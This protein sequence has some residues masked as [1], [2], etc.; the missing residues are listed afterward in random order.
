MK[1]KN[2]YDPDEYKEYMYSGFLG[3]L[4]RRNH[5]LMEIYD[6]KDNSKILEIGG[7]FVPHFPY[8]KHSIKEYHSVDLK[9]VRGLKNYIN[10]N[11]KKIKFKYY[12]G[13][14]LKYKK[15]YFD[16]III[17]HCLEHILEPEKFVN[18]MMRVLKKDGTIS[19]AL[20]CDPGVLWRLGRYI[21]KIFFLKRNRGKDYDHDYVLATE[22]VN[23][24]FNLY[25]ILKKK[26]KIQKEIFYPINI[27]VID[28]N[29]FY[30]CQIKK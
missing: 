3:K 24:I 23:S 22:H 14:K 4:F 26:F 8:V 2:N 19:I 30:I 10:K 12:N 21:M 11:Y 25:V 6:F 7:G 16:R 17:S 28:I 15:N 27:K 9:E 29:L 5:E 1:K 20:P 18:E 13:K